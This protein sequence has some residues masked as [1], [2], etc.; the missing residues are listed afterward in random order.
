MTWFGSLP[1]QESHVIHALTSIFANIAPQGAQHYR[2]TAVFVMAEKQGHSSAHS[3]SP[4][5]VCPLSLVSLLICTAAL[6]RVEI[7]NQRVHDVE[8]LVAADARHNQN[9][10]KVF[11]DAANFKRSER[12]ESEAEFNHKVTEERGDETEGKVFGLLSQ[13]VT[14]SQKFTLFPFL[15]ICCLGLLIFF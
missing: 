9:L 10:I 12:V 15:D 3:S 5:L 1:M 6:V 13:C 7:I 14:F 8:D 2:A 11:T 4:K